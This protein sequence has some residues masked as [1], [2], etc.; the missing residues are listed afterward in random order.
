[1]ATPADGSPAALLPVSFIVF[2]GFLAI[3]LQLPTTALHVGTHWRFGDGIAGL[4]VGLQSLATVASRHVA[5]GFSDRRGPR[6]AVLAGLP[7]LTAGAAL[8]MAATA[9]GREV[10][11]ATLLAGRIALGFGESLMLTGA[12]SWGI[13]RAGPERS[14]RVIAWQ[15]LAMFGALMLGAPIGLALL[16]ERGFAHV[17]LLAVVLPLLGMA[18]AWRLAPAAPIGGERLAF[19]QVARLIGRYGLVLTGAGVPYALLATFLGLW[20]VD[21]GWPGKELALAAFGGGYVL[22]RLFFAD[23]PARRGARAI[24]LASLAVALGG[25]LLVALSLSPAVTIVGALVSGIGFSLIYPALGLEL[26]RITPPSSRGAVIGGFSAFFDVA[27]GISGPIGGLIAAGLGYRAVFVAAALAQ[28][29]ALVLLATA[30][31]RA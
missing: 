14:G 20:F 23:L 22:M 12:M 13:A 27:I 11:L 29:G 10:G 8:T 16:D 19:P 17:A 7:L 1:M 3:S 25:Q 28:I 21:L 2:L 9:L 18:L 6:A 26:M 4:V 15:G 5:G 30:R 31:R 24:A